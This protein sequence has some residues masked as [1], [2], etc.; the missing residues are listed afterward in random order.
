MMKAHIT[1]LVIRIAHANAANTRSILSCVLF[2]CEVEVRRTKPDS[3]PRQSTSKRNGP[4]S[5]KIQM[6]SMGIDSERL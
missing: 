3:F 4:T 1:R 2:A 6:R 5:S